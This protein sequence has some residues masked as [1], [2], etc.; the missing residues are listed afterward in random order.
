MEELQGVEGQDEKEEQHPPGVH[1]YKKRDKKASKKS[2][3][4]KFLK[5]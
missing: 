3:V 4:A 5:V 1:A 2:S